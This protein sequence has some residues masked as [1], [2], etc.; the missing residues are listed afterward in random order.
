MPRQ[1]SYSSEEDEDVP[2][3]SERIERL[4]EVIKSK[5]EGLADSDEN[6]IVDIAHIQEEVTGLYDRFRAL[7]I[8]GRF[9]QKDRRTIDN[10][11][12]SADELV[13]GDYTNVILGTKIATKYWH[14]VVDYEAVLRKYGEVRAFLLKRL[15]GKIKDEETR[16]G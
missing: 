5:A 6:L 14:T 16:V 2:D 7:Q 3:D 8:E 10:L 9:T 13:D 15:G 4:K 11:L 1:R 12:E